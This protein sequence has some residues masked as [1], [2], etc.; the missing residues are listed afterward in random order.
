MPRVCV[1][2]FSIIQLFGTPWTVANQVPLSMGFFRQEY[3]SGVSL[4]SPGD[5]PNQG[6]EFMS[7]VT[8]TTSGKPPGSLST[9]NL[10]HFVGRN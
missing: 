7:P 10:I 8:P 9:I 6:I 1:C 5:H 4:P 2:M 3:W